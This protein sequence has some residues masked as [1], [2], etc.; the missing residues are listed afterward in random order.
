MVVVVLVAL[1]SLPPRTPR[2][3]TRISLDFA[4]VS[5]SYAAA[6]A[7]WILQSPGLRYVPSVYSVMSSVPSF[8]WSQLLPGRLIVKM[9]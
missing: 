2:S 4:N 1:V 9:G 7:D 3:E 6:Q 5:A 8:G